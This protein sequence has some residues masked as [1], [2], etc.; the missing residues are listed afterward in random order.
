MPT[1]TASAAHPADHTTF[2][3]ALGFLV[4]AAALG[5]WMRLAP[6]SP[7]EFPLPYDHVLHAHSHAAFLGW[8]FNAL[9]ALVQNRLLPPGAPRV[10]RRTWWTLQLSAA[11]MVP[12]FL[13]QG[14]GPVSIAFSTVHMAAAGRAC[15]LLARAPVLPPAARL[16]L[17]VAV[18]W[19]AASA[20]A[21]VALGPLAALGMRDSPAYTLAVYFYIHAQA[22]GWFA[23]APL[24]LALG[25]AF[26]V[27]AHRRGVVLLA[28]GSVPTF[29]LA[30]P[31][32][33]DSGWLQVTGFLGGLLELGGLVHLAPAL[34]R[35]AMGPVWLMRLA[36][37]AF[38][39]KCLL[40][41]LATLPALAPFTQQRGTALAFLHLIF[42]GFV[43]AF[44][45][46][47][48]AGLGWLHAASRRFRAGIGLA[49]GGFTASEFLLVVPALATPA[50]HAAAAVLLASGLLLA[51]TATFRVTEVT[52]AP[53]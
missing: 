50:L 49:I 25:T 22:N 1:V 16:A 26:P 6:L 19:F 13:A 32:F 40:Q 28:C 44:L 23:F 20:L 46:G 41:V 34:A 31:A 5:A 29:A 53:R 3:V 30:F 42:L 36:W 24:A 48:A 45:L 14:Y 37:S 18:A 43:T 21:P 10:G 8:I 51:A 27:P 38:A 12:A 11:A 35:P 52:Q 4:L 33:P 9:L 7:R 15:W 39:L 17:R 47:S 2:R